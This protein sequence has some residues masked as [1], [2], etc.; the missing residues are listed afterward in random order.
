MKKIIII[1]IVVVGIG[2]GWYLISPLWRVEERN[3]AF[4]GERIAPPLVKAEGIFAS[5]AHEV[6]GKAHI[7]DNHYSRH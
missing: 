2:A 6:A 1:F 4:P 5:R 3:D 7:Y